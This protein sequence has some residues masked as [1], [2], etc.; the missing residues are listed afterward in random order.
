MALRY[1]DEYRDPHDGLNIFRATRKHDGGNP[2]LPQ[3][4]DNNNP[5]FGPYKDGR[6]PFNGGSGGARVPRRPKTP[7]GG[8]GM[9]MEVGRE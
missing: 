7:A 4:P 2:Y 1:G 6:D 5:D 8:G 9:K 3:M